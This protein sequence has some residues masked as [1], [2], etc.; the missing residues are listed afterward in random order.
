M[1]LARGKSLSVSDLSVAGL[2]PNLWV[3]IQKLGLNCNQHYPKYYEP[4]VEIKI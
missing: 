2:A 3:K 4:D 1:L